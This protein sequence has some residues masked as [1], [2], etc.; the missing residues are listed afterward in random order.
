MEEVVVAERDGCVQGG[1]LLDLQL[2]SPVCI[3]GRQWG[4]VV[5]GGGA[6]VG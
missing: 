6:H 2:S 3:T 5:V 4:R 1:G